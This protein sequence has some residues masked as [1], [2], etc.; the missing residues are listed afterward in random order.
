MGFGLLF[1]GYFVSYVMSYVFIPKLLGCLIMLAG[2]IKLSEY[3]IGFKKCVPVLGAMS[4]ASAYMLVRSALEYFGVNSAVF[5]ELAVNI[6]STAE[7]L[8]GFLFH[9]VLLMAINK[10]AK[11]TG[12]NKLCFRAMRNLVIIAVAEIAYVTLSFIPKSAE[13]VT[14]VIFWIALCLRLIWIVLDLV[15]LAS[16]YRMICDE[17]DAD[18]PDKEVNVPIIKQME[19][20]MRKRDKNAFDSGRLLSEKRF[21]KKQNKKKK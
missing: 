21:A 7:E 18:M 3:E 19:S 17:G 4:V 1:V 20:V 15:L 12:V 5:G 6:V 13:S 8:L 11:D 9:I 16:C 10:I 2:V 14:Q